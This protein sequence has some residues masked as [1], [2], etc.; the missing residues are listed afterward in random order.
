MFYQEIRNGNDFLMNE[1]TGIIILNYQGGVRTLE[2]IESVKLCMDSRIYLVDNSENS[3]EKEFLEKALG[4]DPCVKLII[5]S[6]NS[7]FASGVNIGLRMAIN[8]GLSK[9]VLLNNDTLVC[10]RFGQE[11]MKAL[12]HHPGSLITPLINWDGAVCGGNYYNKYFGLSSD[13]KYM[14]KTGWGFYLSGCCLAFDKSVID[15]IGFLNEKYFMYGEDVEY[16]HIAQENGIPLI[17]LDE[18]LVDHMGSHS[19]QKASFFYEYHVNRSHFILCLSL[20]HSPMQKTLALIGKS[21]VQ[22]IKAIFRAIKYYTL[23]PIFGYF[24]APLNIKIRPRK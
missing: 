8:D 14:F 10:P 7:G 13:K 19:A 1:K 6:L 12:D 9:F 2:C 23:S 11:L 17:L 15:K 18:I 5:N 24:C 16:C 3:K 21:Q 4:D 22:M 20:L